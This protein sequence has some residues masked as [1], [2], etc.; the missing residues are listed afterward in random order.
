MDD[1]TRARIESALSR[2]PQYSDSRI[3]KNIKG[4]NVPMVRAVRAGREYGENEADGVKLSGKSVLSRRP[5][6]S[7]AKFIKR[8]DKGKGFA[9]KDLARKWGMSEKTIKRHILEIMSKQIETNGILDGQFN[10]SPESIPESI[11]E[12]TYEEQMYNE[13]WRFGP[14]SIKSFLEGKFNDW[15]RGIFK[16]ENP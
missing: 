1:N 7:A 2:K 10:Q 3:A 6:D 16:T 13:G 14:V 12:L 11:P 9:A 5:A 15:R 8:L 4:A